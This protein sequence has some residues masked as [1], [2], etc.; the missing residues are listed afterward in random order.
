MV[1]ANLWSLTTSDYVAR[2]GLAFAMVN[3][4]SL[5]W[6]SYETSDDLDFA[7]VNWRS[8][9][10]TTDGVTCFPCK[11]KLVDVSL[12]HVMKSLLIQILPTLICDLLT[13]P[14]YRI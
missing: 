3:F 9:E 11:V 13:N 8:L 12:G 6:P 10:T 7:R 2:G 4:V 5:T 14:G 1:C